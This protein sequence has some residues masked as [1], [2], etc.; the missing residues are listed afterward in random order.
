MNVILGKDSAADY[1]L[2]ALLILY[3]LVEWWWYWARVSRAIRLGVPGA[4]TRFYRNTIAAQWLGTLY[5]FVLWIVWE[6][7]WSTLWLD[8]IRPL[9]FFLG[10]LLA[11]GVI[12]FLCA[13]GTESSEGARP[14]QSGTISSREVRICL[15]VGPW[16][17][18]RT[19]HFWQTRTRSRAS[20]RKGHP[21]GSERVSQPSAARRQ[22][23]C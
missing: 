11:V 15:C 21:R 10:C 8:G 3:L 22:C 18:G 12:I 20:Y 13:S 6:R 17:G 9:R 5:V 16:N 23:I 1:V 2:L 19:T 14:T 4:L 7:S